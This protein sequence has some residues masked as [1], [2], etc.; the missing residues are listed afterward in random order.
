LHA[1]EEMADERRQHEGDFRFGNVH[2]EYD[3]RENA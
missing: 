2:E 1:E 3:E